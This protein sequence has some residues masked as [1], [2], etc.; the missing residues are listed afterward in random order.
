MGFSLNNSIALFEGYVGKK[1]P[2]VRTP[3]FNITSSKDSW[4][5]K[6]YLIHGINGITI[7]EG[8]LL[9]YCLAGI[10]LDF[11]FRNYG[12]FLF[13]SMLALGFGCVF[14]YSIAPSMTTARH[15]NG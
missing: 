11:Y 3:K 7:F 5:G 4:Q 10:Y 2:F 14:Y 9:F 13:H 8:L 6:K 1:I 15:V 12:L